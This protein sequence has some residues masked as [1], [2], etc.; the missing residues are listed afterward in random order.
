MKAQLSPRVLLHPAGYG[1]EGSGV[2]RGSG[3]E[4]GG[5]SPA[6]PKQQ[7]VC[8]HPDNSF[9]GA[10]P[11]DG[12]PG[13]VLQ[14]VPPAPWRAPGM[15]FPPG[16]W[17]L[18]DFLLPTATHLRREVEIFQGVL[19]PRQHPSGGTDGPPPWRGLAWRRS[20]CS[21]PSLHRCWEHH[22]DSLMRWLSQHL[23]CHPVTP[24]RP[25]GAGR[26]GTESRGGKKS[27]QAP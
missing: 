1:R 10:E 14:L 23:P 17:Q 27:V 16:P 21:P 22:W 25:W 2:P 11:A 20:R 26:E 8:R 12:F 5:G 15:C 3:T 6:L 4:F 9:W 19:L 24:S 7:D 13:H 18:T